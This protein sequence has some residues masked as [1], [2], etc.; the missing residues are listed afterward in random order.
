MPK[1]P[2]GGKSLQDRAMEWWYQAD[3]RNEDPVGYLAQLALVVS[4]L[5]GPPAE[6]PA[7][8]G[9]VK[10]ALAMP[11]AVR[12][13]GRDG[14]LEQQRKRFA[15]LSSAVFSSAAIPAAVRAQPGVLLQH[16]D[17]A[18]SLLSEPGVALVFPPPFPPPR[19]ATLSPHATYAC[20]TLK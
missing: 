16:M 4:G 8:A 12:T 13:S 3:E 11:A 15:A 7:A 1:L 5:A 6:L 17:V 9:L 14:P 2:E 19:A 18:E 20:H 10:E